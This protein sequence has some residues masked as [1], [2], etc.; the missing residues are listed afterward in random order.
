MKRMIRRTPAA[1]RDIEAIT[2]TIA[3]DNVS[4]AL[5]F[6]DAAETAFDALADMPAMGADERFT[7]PGLAQYACGLSLN[8][9][10]A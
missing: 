10:T 6:L 3:Q 1:W 7:T 2:A 5:R 4:A 9:R 8:S